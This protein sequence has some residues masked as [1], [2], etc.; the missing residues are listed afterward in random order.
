MTTS[1]EPDELPLS[2]EPVEGW[3]GWRLAYHRG[4]LTLFSL[5]RSAVWPAREAM[6]STCTD[7]PDGPTMRCGCGIYASSSPKTF[8]RVRVLSCGPAVVG[9]VAMWGRIVE[10]REGARS[11]FAYPQRMRLVCALCLSAGRGGVPPVVVVDLPEE[12]VPLCRRHRAEVPGEA[13]SASEVERELLA[14]YAVE[15][16]AS[17]P[18]KGSFVGALIRGRS[19]PHTTGNRTVSAGIHLFSSYVAICLLIVSVVMGG[20]VRTEGASGSS[21]TPQVAPFVPDPPRSAVGSDAPTV[22]VAPIQDEIRWRQ[23]P[24]LGRT[25]DGPFPARR[26]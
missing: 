9:E 6:R 22:R 5:T 10:H 11:Q 7:H 26:V 25:R 20:V 12:L 18:V 14:T 17:V 21:P 8:A 16:L 24:M 2:I 3:R 23:A 15:L 4:R 19:L 13:R 1:P